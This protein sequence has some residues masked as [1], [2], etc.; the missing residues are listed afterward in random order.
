MAHR[1]VLEDPMNG[2]G[3]M[4]ANGDVV[5]DPTPLC[6]FAEYGIGYDDPFQGRPGERFK[7][8]T[9]EDPMGAIG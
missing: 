6:L 9:G 7:G 5:D 8:I 2:L 1:L 3:E 4:L